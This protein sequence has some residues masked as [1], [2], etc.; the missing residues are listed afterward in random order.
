MGSIEWR[1]GGSGHRC[2]LRGAGAL[3]GTP[4]RLANGHRLVVLGCAVLGAR[5]VRTRWG[6]VGVRVFR[7]R[8]EV[9]SF[10]L[11][12]TILPLAGVLVLARH[13][14]SARSLRRS[15]VICEM[16]G[17]S[18]FHS[19]KDKPYLPHPLRFFSSSRT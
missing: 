8:R 12:R 15:V 16:V 3:G 4:V 6:R 11:E 18:S 2:R 5:W 9:G 19:G 17:F 14:G 1:G 13:G 10:V 7:R